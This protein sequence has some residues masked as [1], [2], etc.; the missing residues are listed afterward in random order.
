M[1]RQQRITAAGCAAGLAAAARRSAAAAA[2]AGSHAAPRPLDG[3]RGSG[4]RR[5]AA[6]PHAALQVG[7]GGVQGSPHFTGCD[8]QGGGSRR[9]RGCL[10]SCLPLTSAGRKQAASAA[11]SSAEIWRSPSPAQAQQRAAAQGSAAREEGVACSACMGAVA[12][13]PALQS[14]TPSPALGVTSAVDVQRRH[15]R[16]TCCCR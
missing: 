12:R 15:P 6:P 5:C 14:H 10:Q 11:L 4:G 2:A 16:A 7:R 8:T 13:V 3:C 1:L 9:R